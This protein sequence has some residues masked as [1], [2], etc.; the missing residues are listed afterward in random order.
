[1]FIITTVLILSDFNFFN[2][3]LLLNYLIMGSEGSKD[4]LVQGEDE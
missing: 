4:A 1:M 3:F 2:C